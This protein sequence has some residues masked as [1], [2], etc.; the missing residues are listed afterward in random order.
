MRK[1]DKTERSTEGVAMAVGKMFKI[2]SRV[3]E[4]ERKNQERGEIALLLSMT[5]AF[6]SCLFWA[7][8]M[9]S[10]MGECVGLGPCFGRMLGIFA[11]TLVTGLLLY[12]ITR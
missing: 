11:A 3:K 4:L 12:F 2:E 10:R 5:G 1:K 9:F 8:W 6:L 7:D